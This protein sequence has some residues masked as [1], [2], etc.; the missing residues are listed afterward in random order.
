MPPVN[1]KAARGNGRRGDAVVRRCRSDSTLPGCVVLRAR[2]ERWAADAREVPLAFLAVAV[3]EVRQIVRWTDGDASRCEVTLLHP[4][5]TL[6]RLHATADAVAVRRAVEDAAS[7]PLERYRRLA[8]LRRLLGR[9][10]RDG[11]GEAA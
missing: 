11:R 2:R 9:L 6:E 8:L 1:E 10:P 5:G 4:S 7:G 3:L